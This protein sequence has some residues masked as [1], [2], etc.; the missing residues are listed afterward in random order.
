MNTPDLAKK[1]AAL[2]EAIGECLMAWSTVEFELQFLFRIALD[3]NPVASH[4]VWAAVVSFEARL[5]ILNAAIDANVG[6]SNF[7]ADWRLL[8][9]Y[10]SAQA[11]FR[12][13]VAHG[14]MM[15]VDG[16]GPMIE[17]YFSVTKTRDLLSEKQVR[18]FAGGFLELAGALNWIRNAVLVPPARPDIIAPPPVPDLVLRLRMQAAQSRGEKKLP[19][20]LSGA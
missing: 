13:Q 18:G 3:A 5:K 8:H 20:R 6:D 10:A 12:N 11:R 2:H 19:P 4:A 14:T 1:F 17:P 9:N 7:K 16:A 15:N